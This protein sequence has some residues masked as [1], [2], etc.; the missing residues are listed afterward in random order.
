[1]AL[2]KFVEDNY[3]IWTENNRSAKTEKYG[4]IMFNGLVVGADDARNH[5]GKQTT[6]SQGVFRSERGVSHTAN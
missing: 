1:M 3:E 5:S 2:A 4:G 6:R